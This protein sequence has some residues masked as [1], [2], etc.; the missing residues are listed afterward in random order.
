MK[1]VQREIENR[2]GYRLAVDQHVLFDE[3]PAARAHE[4]RRDLLVEAV[5]FAFRSREFDGAADRVAQVDLAFDHV[6]P[7]R[8]IRVLEVR[9]E[10]I[11]ARV[12]RIDHHLAVGRAGDFDAAVLQ[13]LGRGGDF[14]AAFAYGLRLG[15]EVR[16]L[17][18][19]ELSL[20]LRA[21]AEQLAPP[22]LELARELCDELQGRT[23]ANF[24]VGGRQVAEQLDRVG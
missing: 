4:Q 13:V 23:A 18:G 8:G 11:R 1:E 10:D 14:P 24:R 3:V 12:E 21:A 7:G 16:Q 2:A 22:G 9:H 19:V 6:V 17:A 20:A 5:R 15:Q